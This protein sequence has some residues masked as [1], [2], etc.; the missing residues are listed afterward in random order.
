MVIFKY[1][2]TYAKKLGLFFELNYLSSISITQ[3]KVKNAKAK[4]QNKPK[5]TN[6]S[7]L[8]HQKSIRQV[9]GTQLK[10]FQTVLCFFIQI[11]TQIYWFQELLLFGKCKFLFI[12][13]FL[14]ASKFLLFAEFF[15]IFD[16]YILFKNMAAPLSCFQLKPNFLFIL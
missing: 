11:C 7:E 3:A 2:Y 12:S 14:L 16:S 1:S 13:K 6:K 9:K 15:L 10:L 8:Q 5:P 4:H